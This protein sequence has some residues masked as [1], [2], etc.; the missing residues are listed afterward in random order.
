VPVPQVIAAAAENFRFNSKNL[1]G[2]VSDLTPAEWLSRPNDQS[3]HVAWIV[4]HV[5]WARKAV[6]G[7]L[8]TEWSQPWLTL[9]ERGSK[10]G[11]A[12]S[13]PSSS[14]LI[15][16]WDE[17]SKLVAAAMETASGEV[18]SQPSKQGPPSADGMVSGVVNFL[19]M[20]E[21]LHVG[22]LSYLRSCLGHKGM[23]G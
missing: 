21:T 16:A 19:A 18:L 4:G 6:L 13:Y 14:I 1:V 11:E 5:I 2:L 15:E 3:N 8:G 22:Q 20:H 10:L 17:T 23:M 12:A 7:R 9:F